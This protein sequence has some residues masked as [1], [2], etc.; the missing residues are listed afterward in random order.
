MQRDSL[1]ALW[2]LRDTARAMSQEN[3]ELVRRAIG[4]WNR[5]DL[6]AWLDSF[7]PEAAMRDMQ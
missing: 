1:V 3:V 2:R 6:K 7:H 5:R 4:A